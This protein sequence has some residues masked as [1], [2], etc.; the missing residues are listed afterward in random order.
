MNLAWSC[1]FVSFIHEQFETPEKGVCRRNVVWSFVPPSILIPGLRSVST[2]I[3]FMKHG[4]VP[5]FFG[6]G[7]KSYAKQ[8]I[9]YL[10]MRGT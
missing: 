6:V 3:F 8:N 2:A 9:T 5:L 4:F 7:D 1:L 10:G